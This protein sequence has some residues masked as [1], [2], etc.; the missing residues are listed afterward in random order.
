LVTVQDGHPLALG[1]LGSVLGQRCEALGVD[2][3]GQAGSVAQ[4]YAEYGIDTDAVVDAVADIIVQQAS[5]TT[6][7]S[8]TAE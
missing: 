4:L 8:I 3:F 6:P 7:S 2:R 5:V 1:W